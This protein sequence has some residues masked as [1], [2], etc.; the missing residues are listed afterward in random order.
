M[1]RATL[2]DLRADL[3]DPVV[4]TGR[5]EGAGAADPTYPIANPPG[6]TATYVSTGIY[7]VQFTQRYSTLIS[8]VAMLG[9]STPANL[10]GHTLVRDDYTDAVNPTVDLS[11]YNNPDTGTGG[12]PALHDLVATEF[13]D[14]IAVLQRTSVR[15]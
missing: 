8:F 4:I 14:F 12:Q 9:G 2:Y 15:R 3:K 1:S 10:L 11:V 7:R 5:F 6:W 13:I